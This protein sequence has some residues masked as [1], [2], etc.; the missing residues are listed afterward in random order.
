MQRSTSSLVG[1]FLASS[2]VLISPLGAQ[3]SPPPPA[4]ARHP[5]MPVRRRV[6][7]APRQQAVVARPV[8]GRRI[9]TRGRRV[10]HKPVITDHQVVAPTAGRLP[11]PV[12][13]TLPNGLTVLVQE[14]HAAPV[15]AVRMYV[16]T[17]S[18]Y[19][20]QYLGAG[21]SH[22]FEHTLSEGTQTRT[23]AQISDEEQA[24]G[25]Q[26]N[27]YTSYDVTAYHITTASSYFDRALNLLAD[28]MQNAAFPEAEV[29]TQQGVI[30]NEMNLDEDDPDKVLSDLFYATAFRVHPV[31]FPIIGYQ[32][33]FDRLSREDILN[34]YHTHY[35]PENTVVAIAGDVY[36]PRAQAAVA[37]A[38]K[39]WQRGTASIPPVPDEPLQT[40]PR[41]AAVEKNINLTYLQMGWHTV[42]LQHPDLYALD[43][44][45]QVLGG[46]DSSRLVRVLRER[47]NLVASINATSSTPNY[48]AGIFAV[49]ATLPPANLTSVQNQIWI[50]IGK[51]LR[52]GVSEPELRRAQRQIETSF[53]F[54][55]SNVED[56]AEQIAYDEL[57]TGDPTYSRRYVARIN[58]VTPAQV[59]AVAQKYLTHDGITTAIVR[60]RGSAPQTATKQAEVAVSAPQ[61]FAL[62]NGMR[63]IVRENHAAPTVAMVAMGLG[64]V[65][66]EAGK[67]GVSNLC[68]EMLTR[69]T[70][71]HSEEQLATLVDNLG[72]TLEGFNG[73]NAWG[74]RSQWLTNDWRQG[75]ALLQE[76]MLTP[77]FP[78]AELERSKTQVLA[79]IQ[80]QQD[81]PTSAA[82]LLLRRTFFG[83]HPY[84]RSSLGTAASLQKITPEDLRQ[85]WNRVL[86]SHS[87]VL[88]V[89]GDVNADAV[90]SLAENL[91]SGFRREGELKATLPPITRLEKFTLNERTQPGVA[92]TAVWYGF[93]SI[94]LL[95]PDRDAL[96]VLSAALAGADL[97][98]GRLYRRLRDNQL[99]YDI[100]AFNQ[101]GLDAGM[102]V[103]YA[104]TTRKNLGEVR[105]IIDEEVQR[106]HEINISDEELARAKA[107]VIAAHAIDNQS[108]LAQASEAASN[109]LFGLG[110]RE[111]SRYETEINKIT[112]E[113]VRRVAE[114]YLRPEASALATVAPTQE[115][116]TG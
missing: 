95:D 32:E 17:G 72:G 14:N 40:T 68:T 71:K 35:T 92:Q 15:V 3:N 78:A 24:I 34:Y 70:R 7:S 109:E 39:N 81:D 30:H 113:D 28:E 48:N 18:V 46:G 57:D 38:F 62:S 104:A 13:K 86:L 73:Y 111:G 66:L 82:S 44:L 43:V 93:P 59:Q 42:P 84:G 29:K 23:K 11:L 8:S 55:N 21:I 76:V 52:D 101:A 108:N 41:L 19:E 115:Q 107:M 56:Q 22:L 102:F 63:L 47:S 4:P 50:E 89:Y 80:Q 97:P 98:G 27:A 16:K 37:E 10:I 20:G 85:Y 116:A 51:L 94:T 105:H 69:G 103:I 65:R 112:I 87:T 61:I 31:R 26:S 77:T 90:H 100:H 74:I 96:D 64:G 58:A 6:V 106:M 99:V 5:V 54:N 88:A 9:L 83:L 67:A 60:P 45:A 53:I 1:L 110:F 75:L 33:P 91:F 79:A 2:L 49:R 12:K 36:A 25:G 114:K